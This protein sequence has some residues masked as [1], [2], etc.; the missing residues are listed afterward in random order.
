MPNNPL[1]E[2]AAQSRHANPNSLSAG[3]I[4]TPTAAERAT[5]IQFLPTAA[6]GR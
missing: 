2:A 4:L 6:E 5:A 3:L 1:T